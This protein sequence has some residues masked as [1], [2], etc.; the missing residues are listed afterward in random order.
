MNLNSLKPSCIHV[1]SRQGPR[2]YP[3]GRVPTRVRFS[4]NKPR[5][6]SPTVR[7]RQRQKW[8]A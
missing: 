2:F 7:Q 3:W 6:P 5:A 4:V 1:L 8:A